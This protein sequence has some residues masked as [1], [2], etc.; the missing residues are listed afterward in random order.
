MAASQLSKVM[1]HLRRTV[2]LQEAALTD[3][4]LLGRFIE[5][6]D[7]AA[8]AALVRRH[9]PMVWG[10][11]RRLLKQHD[12]E[13]AFQAAFLVLVRKA[14]SIVPRERVANWLYGVAHQTALQARRNIGRRSARE[15]QVT[16]MPEPA[17]AEQ[18]LGRDL[19][20]LLDQELSRLPD[21]YREVI[22]LS[23][24]EGK[25]RK[26]VARQ[27]DLPE[28]TVGSRLARARA[29]LAKRLSRRGVTLSGGALAAALTQQAASAVVPNS[30]VNTTIKAASLLAAGKAAAGLIPARVAALMEGGLK[31][32]LLSKLKVVTAV[33]MLAALTCA[34]AGMSMGQG[35]AIAG[36]E[37]Q[38]GKGGPSEPGK[39]SAVP[40]RPKTEEW[41][42][43]ASPV[44]TVEETVEA[45]KAN[46]ITFPATVVKVYAD[47]LSIT[48]RERTRTHIDIGGKT[49]NVKLAP[50]GK[51]DLRVEAIYETVLQHLGVSPKARISSGGKEAKL[52]DLKPDTDVKLQLTVDPDGRLLVIGIELELKVREKE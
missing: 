23:D 48:V 45:G 29:M 10:V 1:R 8:F 20:P 31:A 13:D 42:E 39:G 34:I 26:D 41:V 27:L 46:T 17:V 2:L 40:P 5:H 51:T 16:E 22:V 37:G 21:A 14:A 49:P 36:K 30:V 52:A 43:I 25:T 7:D 12:A 32:M 9:G 11:C 38:P 28:G 15:K 35:Q 3:G 18:D 6:R 4:Q 24:L 47:A 50:V 33:V 44:L 19:R